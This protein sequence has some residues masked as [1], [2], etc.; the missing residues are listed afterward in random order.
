V[1][2]LD[3][4][5]GAG[6]SAVGYAQAGFDEI[7]GVDIGNQPH[8]PFTFV[9]A[10]ALNPPFQLDD[11]DLIHASPPCQ[12]FTRYRN[13]V[14]DITDR[15]E[16]L[17]PETIAMLDGYPHVIEN[18]TSSPM[19]GDVELCGSMFG[20]DVR[21]HR[22][23]QASFP[24][25]SP[26]CNHKFWTERKYKSSTGRKNKRFTIEIGAWDEPIE[27]QRQVM[28]MDWP[29]NVREISEA[30]PPAYSRFIG[31]QFLAQVKVEAT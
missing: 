12:H 5:A 31:E 9:Q 14:K 23:F 2:L 25:M 10:D 28:G 4:F 8:Y 3:L 29:V 15:Y 1:K 11:F 20:L 16:N 18:L 24:M 13:V 19:R 30:I 21:R 26:P 27:L 17:L 22:W 7:V 6:G